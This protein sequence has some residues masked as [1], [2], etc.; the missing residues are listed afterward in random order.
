[1]FHTQGLQDVAANVLRIGR[2]AYPVD[3]HAQQGV[4]GVAVG[5]H[6]SRRKN[7]ACP[8]EEVNDLP[9]HQRIL[10]YLRE[11]PVVEDIAMKPGMMSEQHVRGNEALLSIGELQ[12]RDV[13]PYGLMQV[14]EALLDKLHNGNAGKGFGNGGNGKKAVPIGLPGIGFIGVAKAC[15]YQRTVCVDYCGSHSCNFPLVPFLA[16]ICA[17]V[18]GKFLVCHG[19]NI[20]LNVPGGGAGRHGKAKQ[21]NE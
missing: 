9:V 10:R 21:G 1:M 17:Q 7:R 5:M 16:D 20:L 6:F 15:G 11:V 4:A 13:L 19:G 12:L 2:A 3:K 18:V 14:K 8:I